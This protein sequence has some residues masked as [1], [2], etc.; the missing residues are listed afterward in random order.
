MNAE[1]QKE[2]TVLIQKILAA[3]KSG[4]GSGTPVMPSKKSSYSCHID[5]GGAK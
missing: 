5:D 1:V 2:R 3:K 4:P